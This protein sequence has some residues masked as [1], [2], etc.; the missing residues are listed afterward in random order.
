MCDD[1]NTVSDDSDTRQATQ[2]RIISRRFLI[3]MA[4]CFVVAGCGSEQIKATPAINDQAI[5]ELRSETI[6]SHQPVG[7]QRV[8]ETVTNLLWYLFR[9][10]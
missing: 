2:F 1:D 9:P 8:D 7:S 4:T 3:A 6:F 10:G 5:R